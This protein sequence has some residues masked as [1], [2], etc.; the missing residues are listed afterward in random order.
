[1]AAG[2][3]TMAH[4]HLWPPPPPLEWI[5]PPARGSPPGTLTPP[6]PQPTHSHVANS[7]RQHRRHQR[8]GVRWVP[9]VTPGST[10]MT[11][12]DT[13]APQSTPGPGGDL[14]DDWPAPP[15]PRDL[16]DDGSHLTR[17]NIQE[18]RSLGPRCSVTTLHISFPIHLPTTWWRSRARNYPY[19][20]GGSAP[21]PRPPPAHTRDTASRSL[22]STGTSASASRC[23]MV[24]APTTDRPPA[25]L[26]I[27]LRCPPSPPALPSR[28]HMH[29]CMPAFLSKSCPIWPRHEGCGSSTEGCPVWENIG[30]G[31]A[32]W[33]GL[34]PLA[35]AAVGRHQWG[36]SNM[37]ASRPLVQGVSSAPAA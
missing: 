24:L 21:A 13:S 36:A 34:H 32:T 14:T 2:E 33:C 18:L 5:P 28:I 8:E 12:R 15:T 20:G 37:H 17:S 23:G 35:G 26:P 11:H 16:T 7:R 30:S 1:M 25:L 31:G 4:P 3:V 29:A 6:L 10:A 22:T 27:I 19:K 9:W